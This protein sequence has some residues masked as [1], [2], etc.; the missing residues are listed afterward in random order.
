MNEENI[1]LQKVRKSCKAANIVARILM[2]L[3][4]VGCTIAIITGIIMFVNHDYFDD[5]INRAIAEGNSV[6]GVDNKVNI[7]FG[8]FTVASLTPEELSN[9]LPK[10]KLT[11]DIPALENYFRENEDSY[12]LLYGVYLFGVGLVIGIL[13]FAL[14][15]IASM[16]TVILKEGNPF[17]DKVVKK[18]L[19]S[20][21]IISVVLGLTTGLGF[22]VIGGFITWVVY[23]IMDYG[24]TLKI[25]SDETL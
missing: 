2:I 14:S 16:F 13:A 17:S 10:D 11:S 9:V 22:G 12:S 7:K 23:T 6:K 19:V 3:T 8:P 15:I 20:M 4:I 21:I 18:M 5:Q 25:Q 24:R 1:K